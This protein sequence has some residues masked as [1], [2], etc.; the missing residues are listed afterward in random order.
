MFKTEWHIP[1]LL[2]KND[3]ILLDGAN[4]VGKTLF[5]AHLVARFA[6][7]DNARTLYLYTEE[8]E[9]ALK[10]FAACNSPSSPNMLGRKL[11]FPPH[12][13]GETPVCLLEP[14][15]DVLEKFLT[16]H[17]PT[18]CVIDNVD[19][20]LAHGSDLPAHEAM[21]LWHEL[22]DLA[23]EYECT[24]LV[25]RHKGL[26]ERRV[27]GNVSRTASRG[28]RHGLMMHWHP[29]EETKRLITVARRQY[30]PPGEQFHLTIDGQCKVSLRQAFGAM[31][32]E[33]AHRCRSWKKNEQD[34]KLEKAALGVAT[35]FMAEKIVPL[36]EVQQ[37]LQQ[38]GL[39]GRVINRVLMRGPFGV[40]YSRGDCYLTPPHF[41]ATY[42]TREKPKSDATFPELKPVRAYGKLTDVE[43]SAVETV[44]IRCSK[45]KADNNI[46]RATTIEAPTGRSVQ[47]QAG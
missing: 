35:D 36:A 38:R 32:E 4:G 3:A 18:L 23:A 33:P 45:S 46:P 5:A 29:T 26:H 41:D 6:R 15:V 10:H 25:L 24:I 42:C 2:P 20:L 8:Q 13:P 40:R 22:R 16:E 43:I 1:S 17:K 30:G 28:L 39:P 27:Y 21:Q 9:E 44:M 11:N 19:D 34:T 47:A 31:Q 37:K 14:L 7:I 12:E